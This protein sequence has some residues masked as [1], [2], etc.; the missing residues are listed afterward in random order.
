MHWIL[1]AGVC[2]VRPGLPR[3]PL[4][5][6]ALIRQQFEENRRLRIEGYNLVVSPRA[7]YSKKITSDVNFLSAADVRWMKNWRDIVAILSYDP[8]RINCEAKKMRRSDPT[9]FEST[10]SSVFL[11]TKSS[12]KW[13][14]FFMQPTRFL[15][16]PKLS[17]SILLW[18]D[19]LLHRLQSGFTKRSEQNAGLMSSCL[20]S[21]SNPQTYNMG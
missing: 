10:K 3:A 7:K 21:W 17:L 6:T 15:D 12:L 4:G 2:P 18:I 13:S 16:K 1:P 5:T 9:P 20:T 14:F 8:T 19:I 11:S